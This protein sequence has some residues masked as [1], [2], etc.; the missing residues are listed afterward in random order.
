MNRFD[1]EQNGRPAFRTI[2]LKISYV[3]LK[4]NPID[5]ASTGFSMNLVIARTSSII[6]FEQRPMRRPAKY[7]CL[8]KL[9]KMMPE[10]ERSRFKA[11]ATCTFREPRFGCHYSLALLHVYYA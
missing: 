6:M 4:C 11:G 10:L 7:S 9:V 2:L 8:D 1:S 5:P 3:E